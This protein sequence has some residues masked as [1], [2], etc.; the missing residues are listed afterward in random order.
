M[1][2]KVLVLG[3][4]GIGPEVTSAAE[5]VIRRVA[6]GVGLPLEIEH[7][8][9]GGAAYDACGEFITDETMAK[10]RAANAIL[11]GSE[12]GPKWDSMALEGAPEKRSGLTR[13]R[14]QLSLFANLRPIRPFACLVSR[15]TLKPEVLEGV[16]FVILR[17]LCGGSY[18]G[19][20]R[21]I[22]RE[23]DGQLRAFETQSYS[24]SEIERIARTAFRL[25]QTRRNQVISAD[26]S[27]VM[28][29]GF[30]WRQVVTRVGKD[31]F[32]DVH[33]NHMYADNAAM[34]IIR[35]PRQFDVLVTDNLF[36]DILSDGAA[37][38]TGSL[39]ML[40]SAALGERAPGKRHG[41]YEPIHGSATELAG[42]NVANPI[43]AILSA[44]LMFTH[45]FD[46]ADLGRRVESAVEKA[47]EAGARTADIGG[48]S[49]TSAVTEAVLQ[50]L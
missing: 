21:G 50:H 18:F 49:S 30:L 48:S 34:Q 33:L 12:G 9:V 1:S 28:E 27:N 5:R 16:D 6:E 39:G 23:P 7:A 26:K 3:G 19:V 31:E 22:T 37:M 10:A 4:D 38:L 11:F 2:V 36:G 15:S 24:E 47:L 25:A 29:S 8:L 17:E 32:P 20:P 41:L 40:P 45:S 43:G 46:R 13:L 35:E 42:K 44:G 14:R